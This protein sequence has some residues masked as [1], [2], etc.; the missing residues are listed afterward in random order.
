MSEATTVIT[1]RKGSLTASMNSEMIWESNSEGY[2]N[3]LQGITDRFCTGLGPWAGNKF[4]IAYRLIK[5]TVRPDEST[6]VYV[7]D[8]D[9]R[10]KIH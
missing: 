9:E 2:A 3:W 7:E 10:I 8:A 4:V 6:Y 5:E 1:F